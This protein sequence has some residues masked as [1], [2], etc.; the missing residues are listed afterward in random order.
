LL[1][2]EE[3]GT[4]QA[5]LNCA[6][7]GLVGEDRLGSVFSAD[8]GPGLDAVQKGAGTLFGN[9]LKDFLRTLLREPVGTSPQNAVWSILRLASNDGR[10][11]A[12][13]T[14]DALRI[15]QTL[16]LADAGSDMRDARRLLLSITA[17]AAANSWVELTQ[18]IDRAA[19]ALGA[20]QGYTDDE[21]QLFFELAICRAR[22][23]P[24]R[25]PEYKC[26]LPHNHLR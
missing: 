21:T 13:T 3:D 4:P 19:E 8:I 5:R 1:L 17:N 15:A 7:G 12:D 18:S 24:N 6:Q 9:G 14:G 25:S 26:G 11:P 16:P 10:L 23:E 20:D 22:L 2:D